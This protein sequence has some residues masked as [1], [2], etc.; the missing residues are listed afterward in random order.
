MLSL[1]SLSPLSG[2]CSFADALVAKTLKSGWTTSPSVLRSTTPFCNFPCRC[3]LG[4]VVLSLFAHSFHILKCAFRYGRQARARFK[5]AE[6]LAVPSLF[7]SRVPLR[8]AIEPPG[9]SYWG[10]N[11]ESRSAGSRR[12]FSAMAL[13]RQGCGRTLGACSSAQKVRKGEL[14]SPHFCVRRQGSDID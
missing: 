10:P 5:P 13:P 14:V 8:E 12:I 2:I 7:A 1:R 3:I 4:L 11:L 9:V 6:A